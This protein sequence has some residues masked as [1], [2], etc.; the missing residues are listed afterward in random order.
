MSAGASSTYPFTVGAGETL[1]Q[2]L[3]RL[4]NIPLDF[5]PGTRWAYSPQYGFDVLARIV[6]VA[7]GMPLDR[8]VEQR[9]APPRCFASA[10]ASL[11]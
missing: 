10:A 1:A 5:R 7:S 8:F 2:V 4:A 9:I 11:H 3:P 6:E